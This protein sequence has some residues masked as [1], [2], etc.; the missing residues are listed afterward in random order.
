M[1]D[2][3][4]LIDKAYNLIVQNNTKQGALSPNGI[5]KELLHHINIEIF[6]KIEDII[7]KAMKYNSGFDKRISNSIH[8]ATLFWFM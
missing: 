3:N 2:I 8:A 7:A 6:E 5:S 1:E 4:I